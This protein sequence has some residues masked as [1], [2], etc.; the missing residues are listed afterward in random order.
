MGQLFRV[1]FPEFID[2]IQRTRCHGFVLRKRDLCVCGVRMRGAFLGY[3][4]RHSKQPQLASAF[5]DPTDNGPRDNIGNCVY[6][7]WSI[8]QQAKRP[9]QRLF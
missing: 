1:R 5:Q 3:F 7:P 2:N 6:F 9:I 4:S 8:E